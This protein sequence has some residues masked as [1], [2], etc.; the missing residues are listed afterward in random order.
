MPAVVSYAHNGR[1]PDSGNTDEA[2]LKQM[3]SDR[4]G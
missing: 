2:E 1:W 4:A 3:M